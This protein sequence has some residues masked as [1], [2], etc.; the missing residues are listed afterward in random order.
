MKGGPWEIPRS[1]ERENLVVTG[2]KMTQKKF[3][4]KPVM[5][6]RL[7]QRTV[8]NQGAPPRGNNWEN[9]AAREK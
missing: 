7:Q 6:R 5:G 1:C 9:M 3:L 2:S 4:P 8:G